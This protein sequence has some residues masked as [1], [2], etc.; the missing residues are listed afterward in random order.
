MKAIPLELAISLPPDVAKVIDPAE[1]TE[2]QRAEF[3]T[4]WIDAGG[5]MGDTDSPCPWCAPW[6]W[7]HD[8]EVVGAD[9]YEWGAD[10]WKSVKEDVERLTAS[11]NELDDEE[12]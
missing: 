9:P 2:E 10:H 7:T 5:Y 8:L 12:A 4:G 3:V 6:Y 1:L 11:E